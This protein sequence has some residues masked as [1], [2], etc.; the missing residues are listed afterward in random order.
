MKRS[1]AILGHT[2][3]FVRWA[4]RKACP[5]RELSEKLADD[6]FRQ[7]RGLRALSVG[8]VEGRV[9][10]GVC[11]HPSAS[12]ES[13]DEARGF[14]ASE[15]L[16]AHGDEHYVDGC[17][18]RC[19]AN[20]MEHFAP[21]V[22][23]GCYG[24]LPANNEFRFDG[25]T[26][27][28]GNSEGVEDANA[29]NSSFVRMVDW[30][31]DRL[32]LAPEADQLFQVTAPRWYGIWQNSSLSPAQVSLLRKVFDRIV[33]QFPSPSDDLVHFQIALKLCDENQL[34]LDCE[35][36]PPGFSDGRTWTI[37]H[38]CPDCSLASTEAGEQTCSACGRLGSPLE[39]RRNK[40]LGLR[41]YVF[42]KGVIGERGTA[43]LIANLKHDCG[44]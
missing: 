44:D 11:I 4:I 19:P 34:A 24:W 40:V 21:G 39:V 20:A 22:W 5:L 7:L 37:Q 41:P 30:A 16:E 43:E 2:P 8:R 26:E 35:L 36:I 17:C 33:G 15:V 14:F 13:I 28:D 27:A 3:Q 31:I 23:A 9:I 18:R 32:G 29:N 12:L 6:S 1:V 25:M 10:K 42:L 38:C